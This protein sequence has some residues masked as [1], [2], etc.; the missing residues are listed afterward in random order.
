MKFFK[1]PSRVELWLL[2][3]A[4]LFLLMKVFWPMKS[5][6]ESVKKA[7]LITN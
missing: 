6:S 3:I 2:I 5:P 4:I 7:I 1:K